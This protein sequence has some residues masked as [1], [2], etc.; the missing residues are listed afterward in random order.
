M[1][2]VTS[3]RPQGV[4]LNSPRRARVTVVLHHG[5]RNGAVLSNLADVQDL[6]DGGFDVHTIAPALHPEVESCLLGIGS[7]VT[8][9]DALSQWWLKRDV[10]R[11]EAMQD[12]NLAGFRSVV[13]DV[14]SSSPDVVLSQSMVTV[15]GAWAASALFVPHVW[16]LREYGGRENHL[17][18]PYGRREMA[19]LILRLSDLV[20]GN[21]HG[22]LRA[23]GID[24]HARTRVLRP[25]IWESQ[26]DDEGQGQPSRSRGRDAFMLRF[27]IIGSL[28][29]S[30]GHAQVFSAFG[31]FVQ[32]FP[33]ARLHVYGTGN[34]HD[35]QRL[36]DLRQELGLEDV[37]CFNGEVEAREAYEG[38]DVLIA[39][40]PSESFGR[41]PHEA[42]RHGIPT[43]F[44]D[45]GGYAEVLLDGTTGL[46]FDPEAAGSLVSALR[47]MTEDPGLRAALP[48]NLWQQNLSTEVRSLLPRY[49]TETIAAQSR[50]G[51]VLRAHIGDLLGAMTRTAEPSAT[52][53]AGS[54][55]ER[56][57]SGPHPVGAART[58]AEREKGDQP[59]VGDMGGG[60][61]S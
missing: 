23:L 13:D 3:W 17:T 55:S 58:G 10:P 1:A 28:Q 33:A 60:A 50:T 51:G 4:T 5:G 46:A 21:S 24:G 9:N 44:A 61:D 32:D 25:R 8:Q 48:E 40:S 53:D 36:I 37:I 2:M 54:S 34:R 42:A 31:A 22:V 7:S 11:R 26:K 20:I 49:V 18:L 39:P 19:T 14:R 57:R 38:I 27:G 52:A 6:I 59:A 43:I 45:A 15:Y 41:T 35:V 47:R 30:K 12:L 56:P 16:Y 29:P